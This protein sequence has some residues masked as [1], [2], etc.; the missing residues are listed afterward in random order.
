MKKRLNIPK[1]QL[2]DLYW[3]KKLTL[4][5]IGKEF[6]CTGENIIYWLKKFRIE[7]R[8]NQRKIDIPKEVLERLYWKEN[9]KTTEIAKRYG[10]KHGRTILK[11]MKK[12]GVPS[13]TL[14]EARTIKM[15]K[16][17]SG[18]LEEKA[19]FLGLR[20]GDFYAKKTHD[21]VRIQTTTTH[22]AQVALLKKSFENYGELGVYLSKNKKR[23]TEWFIYIDLHNSFNF[24]I[25]KPEEIPEEIMNDDNA[26]FNFLSAYMDC[27][28]SW[29]VIKSHKNSV[30]FCF[31]MK[32]GDSKI[33]G[34]FK[35]KLEDK[36]YN[37]RMYFY[38][39]K[40]RRT[41]YGT[42]KKD[43]YD[44][45]LYRKKEVISIIKKLLPLSKH[46]EKIRRMNFILINQ[47]RKWNEIEGGLNKLRKEIKME[48]LKNQSNTNIEAK[49]NA[50][51]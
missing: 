34:Q 38:A 48:L 26:F 42:Y 50:T 40:G 18:P 51:I 39:K 12:T 47:N 30:R 14:S 44:L 6:G 20:A 46:S 9:L 27:E 41:L 11:K 23:D 1:E 36:N 35:K 43:I 29:D 24:L 3:N 7:K 21:C 16:P 15:K 49:I 22:L 33:L 32:T 31:R 8:P 19:Y 4:V 10:I 28:G 5:E 2:Y 13:K 25:E 17:F 45:T 37:P